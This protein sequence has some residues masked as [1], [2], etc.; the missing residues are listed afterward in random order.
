[1]SAFLFD[2]SALVK[3]YLDE[4]GSDWVRRILHP[5]LGHDII[6]A[7]TTPVELVA[8]I[9]RRQRGG[10]LTAEDAETAI[11]D[12]VYDFSVQYDVLALS[13]MIVQRAMELCRQHGLRGYDGVQLATAAFH[14][15]PNVFGQ[16]EPLVFVSSDKELNQ[17]AI[18][19]GLTVFDPSQVR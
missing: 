1:M 3:R 18:T 9:S 11:A 12:L 15:I 5:T 10:A 6:V 16:S 17:A 8:A 14:S 7:Q 4:P 19:E 13:H 2:S